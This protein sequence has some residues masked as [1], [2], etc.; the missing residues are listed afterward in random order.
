MHSHSH[1]T[2]VSPWSLALIWVSAGSGPR[3]GG[4]PHPER[5]W[6]KAGAGHNMDFGSGWAGLTPRAPE[7]ALSELRP[8]G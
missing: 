5:I 6:Q 7:A 4:G 8:R 3:F 2:E 1:L